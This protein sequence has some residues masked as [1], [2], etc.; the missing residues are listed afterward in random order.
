MR[1][2]PEEKS[3]KKFKEAEIYLKFMGFDVVNPWNT[4][5]EKKRN[6][7]DWGDF[8][9]Y[10]LKIIKTCD[11]IFMLDNWKNSQGAKCE[12]AFACGMKINVIY[13]ASTSF[14]SWKKYIIREKHIKL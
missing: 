5:D 11:S 12:H 13:Q 7:K 3:R 9:L 4:E 2:L 6:C 1:G 8:I 14:Y 10:D